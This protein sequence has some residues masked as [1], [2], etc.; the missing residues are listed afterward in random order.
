MPHINLVSS[1][2]APGVAPVRVH[3]RAA[4]A[5]RP[6]VVLHGGSGYGMYPFDG[7]IATLAASHRMDA[8]PGH[9]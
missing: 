3:D 7:Q 1:A 6:I 8:R 5:G 9:L 4:G 2:L